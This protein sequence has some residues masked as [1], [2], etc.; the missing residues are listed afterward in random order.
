MRTG[1]PLTSDRVGPRFPKFLEFSPDGQHVLIGRN[2]TAE[3]WDF[4]GPADPVPT[5]FVDFV[6][7][8]AN[9]QMQGGVAHPRGELPLSISNLREIIRQ[10][11]PSQ[12]NSFWGKLAQRVVEPN[13]QI[14]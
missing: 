6:E 10:L 13:T 7:I 4:P 3:I 9:V 11:T 2:S 5:W 1:L 12:R 8:V 14:R